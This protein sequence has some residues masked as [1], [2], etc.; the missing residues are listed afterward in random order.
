MLELL[1]LDS[2][3]RHCMEAACLV[4]EQDADNQERG[5]L[6][7]A[8]DASLQEKNDIILLFPYILRQFKVL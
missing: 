6:Q 7:K 5:E 8:H 1:S 3:E 4:Q 2:P